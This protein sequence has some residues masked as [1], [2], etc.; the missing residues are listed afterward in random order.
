MD[1]NSNEVHLIWL[2]VLVVCTKLKTL[3]KVDVNFT[4][5]FAQAYEISHRTLAPLGGSRT[6]EKLMMDLPQKIRQAAFA[7]ILSFLMI[8]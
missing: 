4:S 3:I 6:K 2:K 5:K 1:R 8:A 7:T